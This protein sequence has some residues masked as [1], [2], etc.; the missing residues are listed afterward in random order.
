LAR[1]S[2]QILRPLQLIRKPWEDASLHSLSR[3]DDCFIRIWDLRLIPNIYDEFDY[4]GNEAS[5]RIF[6]PKNGITPPQYAEKFLHDGLGD[7][8]RPSGEKKDMLK[9]MLEFWIIR[10]ATWRPYGSAERLKRQWF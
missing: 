8:F 7:I 10:N 5:Y 6:V 2:A 9:A 3:E 4:D 1:A